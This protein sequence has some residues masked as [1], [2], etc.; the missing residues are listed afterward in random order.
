S[1]Y[2]CR[3]VASPDRSPARAREWTAARA[4]GAGWVPAH[5]TCTVGTARPGRT[6]VASCPCARGRTPGA[7][8]PGRSP[9]SPGRRVVLRPSRCDL[10]RAIDD[11]HAFVREVPAG[12]AVAAV[13]LRLRPPL[14]LERSEHGARRE[15]HGKQQLG[16]GDAATGALLVSTGGAHHS[17]LTPR[18]GGGVALGP[19][20]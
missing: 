9:R 17:E 14:A 13:A 18:R 2:R 11:V 6:R 10:H 5:T 20:V 15:S 4:T 7:L 12:V 8:C 1:P 19:L 3:R 16:R